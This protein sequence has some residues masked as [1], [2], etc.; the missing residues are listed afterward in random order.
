[1]EIPVPLESQDPTTAVL[2]ERLNRHM[3]AFEEFRHENREELRELRRDMKAE[4]EGV[5]REVAVTKDTVGGI[6]SIL[7]N[8]RFLWALISFVGFVVMWG[9]GFIEKIIRIWA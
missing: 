4:I 2:I 9:L 5:R 7:K 8:G 1:M 3:T 6:E